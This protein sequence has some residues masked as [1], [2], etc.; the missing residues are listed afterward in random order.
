MHRPSAMAYK[1]SNILNTDADGWWIV[2]TIV[3]P[4]WD[5][6][7]SNDTTCVDVELSKLLYGSLMDFDGNLNATR[8]GHAMMTLILRLDLLTSLVHRKTSPVDCL[9]IL[10]RLL[11]VFVVL[12]INHR[13]V[14][15]LTPSNRSPSIF[16]SP[17]SKLMRTMTFPKSFPSQ[18]Q[19]HPIFLI[20]IRVIGAQF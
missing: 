17:A 5:N 10:V 11:N 1:W 16:R 8:N 4:S 9:L 19:T 14:F 3:R 7:F 2:Q 12:S 13:L 20:R 6:C 15:V 18:N